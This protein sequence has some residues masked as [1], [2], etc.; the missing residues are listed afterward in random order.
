MGSRPVVKLTHPGRGHL[1]DATVE[2]WL[3]IASDVAVSPAPGAP[4]EE[5][6]VEIREDSTIRYLNR[7]AFIQSTAIAGK[8]QKLV[9]S[10]ARSASCGQAKERNSF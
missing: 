10:L 8:S 3:P 5:L 7:A 6:L 1:A 2:V 9:A 4:T